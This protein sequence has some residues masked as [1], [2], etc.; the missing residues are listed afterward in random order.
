V[1][2]EKMELENR[3]VDVD[4]YDSLALTG[5]VAIFQ[6][7]QEESII[8]RV[9]SISPPLVYHDYT[10]NLSASDAAGRAF[11]AFS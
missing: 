9:F 7:S 10:A 4:S 11:H 3:A 6:M 8:M 5:G 1:R 2:A